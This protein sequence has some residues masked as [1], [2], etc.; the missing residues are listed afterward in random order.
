MG[1]EQFREDGQEEESVCMCVWH[2]CVFVV[3]WCAVCMCVLCGVCSY[4]HVCVVL[5]DMVYAC[6]YVVC[7]VLYDMVYACVYVVCVVLCVCMLCVV[8]CGVCMCICCVC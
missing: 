4:M 2:A 7:V 8:W 1:W 6:A 3:V 5:Y